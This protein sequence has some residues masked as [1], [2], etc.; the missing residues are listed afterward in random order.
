MDLLSKKIFEWQKPTATDEELIEVCRK[1]ALTEFIENLPDKWKTFVGDKGVQLSG[2]QK[3][4]LAISRALLRDP[5]IVILD[6]ATS[7]LDSESE[8]IIQRELESTWKGK[9][10]IMIAHRLST[11]QRVDQIIVIEKG[12][13][14]QTGDPKTLQAQSGLYQRLL[15][16]QRIGQVDA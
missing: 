14:V 5:L 9:T 16:Y 11:I 7:S 15:E 8:Q 2:G 3:Q 10:I 12:R 4:R 6:E 1:T 13:I